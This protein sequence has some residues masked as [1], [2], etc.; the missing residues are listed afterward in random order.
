MCYRLFLREMISRDNREK[1]VEIRIDL[2][3]R[4]LFGG[5]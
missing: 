3:R 2:R 4:I 1:R 5:F